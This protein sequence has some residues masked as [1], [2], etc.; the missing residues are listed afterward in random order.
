MGLTVRELRLNSDIQA[1]ASSTAAWFALTVK[2]QHESVTREGLE[3]K[4]LDSFVPM[5]WSTRKWSD[6][7]KRIQLPLFPGYVFCRFKPEN[8]LPVLQ[9]VGVRSVVGFGNEILPIPE[10]EIEQIR[11][12]LSSGSPVEPWPY[13]QAGQRVRVHK[14]PLMGLDG[15]LVEVRSTYKIVVGIQLLQRSVAVQLDRCQVT[16]L[17]A[18]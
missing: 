15:V 6:R 10:E 11:R 2:T 18:A 7:T 8:R 14:G 1:A 17:L 12:M 13:L 9:T 5:F 4:G 16:P 3:N